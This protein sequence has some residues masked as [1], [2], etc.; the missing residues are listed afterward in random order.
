M[1]IPDKICCPLEALI[2]AIKAEV[3][4][5]PLR[6]LQGSERREFIQIA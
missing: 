5:G 4:E 3:L 6:L 2:F 1:I